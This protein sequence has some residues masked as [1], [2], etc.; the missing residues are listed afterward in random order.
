[1]EGRELYWIS[2]IIF[3]FLIFDL[4]GIMWVGGRLWYSKG[5]EYLEVYLVIILKGSY[6][7]DLFIC[8]YYV[9]VYY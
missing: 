8:Y 4:S 2:F 6:I 5:V 9:S 7:V 3:L 1:M